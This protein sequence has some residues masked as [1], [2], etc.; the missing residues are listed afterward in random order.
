MYIHDELP[1]YMQKV[2]HPYIDTYSLQID[3]YAKHFCV[4]LHYA[5]KQF[6][7]MSVDLPN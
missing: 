7:N 2:V 6:C 1:S 5:D 4:H 3:T